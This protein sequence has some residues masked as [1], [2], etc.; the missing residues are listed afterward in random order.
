MA[1]VSCFIGL[2]D[3]CLWKLEAGDKADFLEELRTGLNGA[4]D[5]DFLTVDRRLVLWMVWRV[6]LSEILMW[7]W[8]VERLCWST[9]SIGSLTIF[10]GAVIGVFALED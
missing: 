8:I 4:G 7:F 6:W 5:F 3:T 1:E 10:L 2:G 9:I